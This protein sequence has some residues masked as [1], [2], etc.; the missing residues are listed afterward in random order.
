MLELNFWIEI[1]RKKKKLTEKERFK[2]LQSYQVDSTVLEYLNTKFQNLTIEIPNHQKGKILELMKKGILEGWCWQ[3]TET[4]ILFLN[5][6]DYIE[7]GFLTFDAITTYYHS[8]ICFYL[9]EE[10][11]LDP[12]L[13][14]LCPK[15]LYRKIFRTKVDAKITAKQVRDFFVE[16]YQKT[17][18]ENLKKIKDYCKVIDIVYEKNKIERKYLEIKFHASENITSPMYRNTTGY[19]AKIDNQ[20][21]KKLV[22]HYDRKRNDLL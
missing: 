20:K 21:V 11:V 14:I 2:I 9:N 18:K 19:L 10:Y 8:W 5:D 15:D 4:A 3:T 6:E 22:A 7:R 13:N 1:L 16:T 17:S 12:C